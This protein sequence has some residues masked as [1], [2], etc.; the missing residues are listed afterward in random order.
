M[1]KLTRI[2]DVVGCL[3]FFLGLL[4]LYALSANNTLLP[5]LPAQLQRPFAAAVS[6][7]AGISL[8]LTARILAALMKMWVR[9]ML[10]EQRRVR[11][12]AFDQY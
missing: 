12:G 6:T 7:A 8:I 3:A 5:D 4:W 1:F 2:L 11:S 10:E 9:Q